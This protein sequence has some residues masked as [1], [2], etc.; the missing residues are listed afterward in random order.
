MSD[1]EI[2]E[3]LALLHRQMHEEG[4]RHNEVMKELIRQKVAIVT[5]CLHRNAE[6][7]PIYGDERYECAVCGATL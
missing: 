3:A 7:V 2:V 4:Q 6:Y 1:E 5:S